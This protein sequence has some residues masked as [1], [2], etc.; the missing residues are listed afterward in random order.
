MLWLSWKP[1]GQQW[2]RMNQIN[3]GVRKAREAF[4][5]DLERRFV[6]DM[7]SVQRA[8]LD[9]ATLLDP[10]FK[11][12]KFPGLNQSDFDAEKSNAISALRCA[13]SMDW[14]PSNEP[15]LSSESAPCNTK[16]GGGPGTS[17]ALSDG[18]ALTATAMKKASNGSTPGECSVFFNM[19]LDPLAHCFLETS[20][21]ADDIAKKD[22]LDKYL[23][24]PMVK[25]HNLDILAWWKA[26]STQTPVLSKMAR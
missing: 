19:P 7:P 23:E 15:A 9:I 1:Q 22:E 24:L 13:W 2:L 12:Y 16:G 26:Q 20:D 10:R 25:D 5:N 14:K 3:L 18:L 8:E 6:T 21:E 4:H 17:A 11:T